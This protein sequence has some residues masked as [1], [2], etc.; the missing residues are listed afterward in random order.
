MMTRAVAYC[1]LMA[2]A[3]TAIA[4]VAAR[5]DW[6]SDAN[7]FLKNFVNHEFLNVLGVTLAITLASAANIHLAFNKIEE[8]FDTPGGL[9]RSRSDLKQNAFALISLFLG[10]VALVLIKPVAA[11]VPV[12]EAVFNMA[13]IG[14]LLWHVLLLLSLVQLVFA[15]PPQFRS[16]SPARLDSSPPSGIPIDT[17]S[18]QDTQ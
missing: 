12:G 15:I 8:D 10:A 11:S 13:A 16:K 4:L 5:P 6:I 1:I 9:A 17:Q 18:R 14:I 7:G 3:A 2:Y